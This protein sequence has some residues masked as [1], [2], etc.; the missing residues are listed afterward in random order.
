MKTYDTQYLGIMSDIIEKGSDSGD[1]TGTGTRKVFTRMTRWNMA[2][3]F[4]LLTTKKLHLKSIVH[5]LLWLISGNTNIKY[6][7]DHAVSIWDEWAVTEA[8]FS[9]IRKRMEQLRVLIAKEEHGASSYLEYLHEYKQL[10]LSLDKVQVGD[11]GP[12]YGK[13]W[14]A[15]PSTNGEDID[16]LS[17]VIERIKSKP[18][19]RRHI[20]NAW[21]PEFLPVDGIAPHLQPFYGKSGRK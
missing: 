15:W 1:R 17:A 11:L 5:E 18:D 8:S 9:E 12:I 6:L 7:Q 16:Q 19:C 4:P 3:G 14:R 21:N 10:Q 13:M 20:V 2:D